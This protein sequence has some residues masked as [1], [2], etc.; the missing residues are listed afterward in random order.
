MNIHMNR[1]TIIITEYPW[2]S[3]LQKKNN[4]LRAA[5][6]RP[7]DTAKDAQLKSMQ[8]RESYPQ[9]AQFRNQPTT[10]DWGGEGVSLCTSS[11]AVKNS[12]GRG[13]NK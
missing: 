5:T 2:L 10:P 13:K 12:A 6:K 7:R 3:L 8:W 11:P 4:P 1:P 9:L